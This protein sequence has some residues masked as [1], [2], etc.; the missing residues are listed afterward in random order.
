LKFLI[1]LKQQPIKGTIMALIT[2]K[3]CSTQVSNTAESCPSCGAKVPKNLGTTQWVVAIIFGLII[4]SWFHSNINKGSTHGA[5]QAATEP[6]VEVSSVALAT[7]YEKNEARADAIYKGKV[8]RV[9]GS[10]TD[11]I[12]DITDNTVVIL[13][14]V[15]EFLG[16]HAELNKSEEQKAINL[17]KGQNITVQCES[18][19]EIVSAP[20][21]E[22][23]VIL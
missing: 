14:G 19:G 11:I 6:T 10:V 7:A 13:N 9:D 17:Q 16:V 2:C 4:F 18:T 20:M 5:S 8:L 23:C 22:K 21:L 3:E 12:K 1:D 15:N